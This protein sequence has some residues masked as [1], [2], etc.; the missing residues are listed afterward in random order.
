M[1]T[2]ATCPTHDCL[3]R[4]CW[5]IMYGCDGIAT[6]GGHRGRRAYVC[7]LLV[8]GSGDQLLSR[9]QS[10]A[11]KRKQL[12]F[13]LGRPNFPSNLPHPP[14]PIVTLPL[15]LVFTHTY[16]LVSSRLPQLEVLASFQR[17]C[18]SR[19]PACRSELDSGAHSSRPLSRQLLYTH[20][21]AFR[22]KFSE[23]SACLVCPFVLRQRSRCKAIAMTN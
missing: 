3:C 8:S 6:K 4:T 7:P 18:W 1:T 19:C 14:I 22:H 2:S 5:A 16:S 15:I 20:Q 9:R 10:A 23:P 13:R 11:R 21:H 12:C 17:S